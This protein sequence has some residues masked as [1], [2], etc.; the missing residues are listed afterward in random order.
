[1]DNDDFIKWA[2]ET[3]VFLVAHHDPKG[4]KPEKD[5]TKNEE[6][7]E[8]GEGGAAP[9]PSEE[10]PAESPG[11]LSTG[12]KDGPC[13][14]YPGLRC[15]HHETIARD[16]SN[17]P[18]GL[19]KIPEHE[20]VPSSWLIAPNGDIKPIEGANQQS[21]GKIQDIADAWLKDLGDHIPWKKWEKYQEAF[22]DGDDAVAKGDWKAALKAYSVVDAALKKA[23]EALSARLAE[24]V[25]ALEE[26]SS[27]AWAAVRDGEGDLAAK[28]KAAKDL[29]AKVSQ[30]LSSGPL[31]VKAEIETW[32][33]ENPLPKK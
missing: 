15:S 13:P 7:A 28:H 24:R 33:K 18:E 29:L 19:P 1:M 17:A 32:V 25:K 23:P 27:A 8:E 6:P 2:N 16:F 3:I 4:H 21:A 9:A 26:K 22:R 11:E 31:P 5:E 10:A 14:L 20:G 30:R 12:S